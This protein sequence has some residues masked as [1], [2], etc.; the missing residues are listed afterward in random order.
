MELTE[1]IFYPLHNKAVFFELYLVYADISM[2]KTEYTLI[3]I[4]VLLLCMLC[5]CSSRRKA[6]PTDSRYQ[7]KPIVEVTQEQLEAEALMIDGATQQQLG[8]GTEAMSIYHKILQR[9]ASYAPAQY[10]M[11]KTMLRMGWL[12]SALHYTRQACQND[13]ENVWYQLQLA[14]IYE[15]RHDGKNLTATWE[16]I[17]KQHPDVVDYYYNLSNAYLSTGDINGGIEVLDRVEKRYGVSETVSMQKHKLWN[18]V[19]APAKARKEMEKLAAAIPN[20]TRYTAILAESYMSEKN[21]AKALQFY[22]TILERS[23]EDENVHIAMA[24]CHLAM[25]DLAQAY[26][27][28]RAGVRNPG[29]DCKAKMLYINEF[30][31]RE[32]FFKQY[33]RQLFQLA[34]TLA[35]ACPAGGDHAFH[36]GLM[37]AGQERY[38]EAAEQLSAYVEHDN[39]LY[40]A[41]DALLICEG[42]VEDR[43]EA[44]MEHARKAAE[45]FPLHPRPYYVLAEGALAQGDCSQATEHIKRCLT[46]MPND[47]NVKALQQK[48]KE[49]CP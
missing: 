1:L 21:Y 24:E 11:G 4:N 16:R 37:L 46:L 32:A 34:D 3:V 20:D 26:R 15:R 29:V 9:N 10:E 35:A 7:R 12:D 43:A 5:S 42:L 17:V 8:N 39:S 18:A 44:R 14:H 40:E 2:R 23:P 22:Q 31:R 30:L 38:A 49:A 48:I 27:H 33:A 47:P 19:N 28:L 41:W 36:Y 25:N 13:G 45:L 6:V